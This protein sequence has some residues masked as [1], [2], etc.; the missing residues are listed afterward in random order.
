MVPRNESRLTNPIRSGT[1][2]AMESANPFAQLDKLVETKSCSKKVDVRI[3]FTR[4]FLGTRPNRDGIKTIDVDKRPGESGDI[5]LC[6]DTAQ[7]R[8]AIK[9]AIDSLGLAD[10][11]SVDFIRFPV[12]AKAPII[13]KYLKVFD[14][15]N[16]KKN[17]VFE[18]FPAGSVLSFSVFLL[19]SIEGDTSNNK[20]PLTE[21]EF[22]SCL[23]LVGEFIGISP[24]GSKFGYGR[25]EVL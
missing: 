14:S 7:W 21:E 12:K 15:R 9:E 24:W 22:M 8:W 18:C 3:K 5:M 6:I 13:T 23:K 11:T 4:P 1:V 20:R 10:E 25:F 16:P 17:P 2:T 19:G